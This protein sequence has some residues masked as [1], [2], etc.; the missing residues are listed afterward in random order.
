MKVAII[1]LL[2]TSL[3]AEVAAAQVVHKVVVHKLE[4]VLIRSANEAAKGAL[5]TFAALVTRENYRAMGF[6]SPEQV[7]AARMGTPVQQFMIRLDELKSY[8]PGAD[9]SALLHSTETLIYP[10]LVQGRTHSSV[11][12]RRQD[13]RWQAESFGL[14]KYARLLNELRDRLAAESNRSPSEYF[15][16]RVPALNVAFLGHT[17]NGRLFL[18]PVFDAPRFGFKRG[19]TLPAEEVIEAILPAAREHTGLP[20]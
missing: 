14:P 10:V 18:T 2:S 16:V 12:L 20:T 4:E 6:D 8:E 19:V 17:Q 5:Q 15:E 1:L 13:D 11:T 7:R 9:L 3:V